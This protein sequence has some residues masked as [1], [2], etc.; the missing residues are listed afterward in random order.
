MQFTETRPI[1]SPLKIGGSYLVSV[2]DVN[3]PSLQLASS[4]HRLLVQL[5]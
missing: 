3:A 4:W 2:I 5:T 1:P